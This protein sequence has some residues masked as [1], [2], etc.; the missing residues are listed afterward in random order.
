MS[1]A[2]TPSEILDVFNVVVNARYATCVA[3][4]LIAYDYVLTLDLEI[5]H[6]WSQPF[7]GATILYL[8]NRY[9]YPLQLALELVLISDIIPLN[10]KMQRRW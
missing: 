8:M 6:I 7:S 2:P 5:N 1:D 4:A 3:T 9:G 10:D